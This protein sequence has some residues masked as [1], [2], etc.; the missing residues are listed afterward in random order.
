MSTPGSVLRAF[1]IP[2]TARPAVPTSAARWKVALD[3]ARRK[4]L[5]NKS[6]TVCIIFPIARTNTRKALTP[7]SRTPGNPSRMVFQVWRI[8]LPSSISAWPS[9]VAKNFL[10]STWKTA[11]TVSPNV[12]KVFICACMSLSSFETSSLSL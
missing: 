9:S 12:T 10:I 5:S 1:A 7:L 6:E 3:T 11:L 4:D 2:C 8:F